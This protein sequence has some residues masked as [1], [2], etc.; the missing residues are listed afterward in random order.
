MI[1]SSHPKFDENINKFLCKHHQDD[2]WLFKLQNLLISH[3]E[4]GTVHLG[5]NVLPTIGAHE[6]YILYK[7]YMAVGGVSKNQRPRVC[8]AK[9]DQEIIFLC[10][11]THVENY[12]TR[13]L[14]TLGKKRLKEFLGQI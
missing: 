5:T 12:T 4:K 6:D 2:G 10:F 3:F 1:Y 11:G 7:V 13:E 8:F 9:K 14:I